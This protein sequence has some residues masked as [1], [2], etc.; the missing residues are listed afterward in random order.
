MASSSG[1]ATSRARSGGTRASVRCGEKA[2]F[3]V[4]KPSGASSRST[5]DCRRASVFDVALDVDPEDARRLRLPKRPSLPRCSS[6]GAMPA[7]ARAIA[8]SMSGRRLGGRLAE[9]LEREVDALRPHPAQAGERRVALER[10]AGAGSAP[11]ARLP[12]ARWRR[13]GGGR[14]TASSP[15]PSRRAALPPS[16]AS[17]SA[18]VVDGACAA[19]RSGAPGRSAGSRCR[20]GG[21]R[22]DGSHRGVGGLARV[23][24]RLRR[25]V[26]VDVRRV[27]VRRCR[28]RRRGARRRCAGRGACAAKAREGFELAAEAAGVVAAA[29]LRD[30]EQ[31]DQAVLRAPAPPGVPRPRRSGPSPGCPAAARRGRARRRRRSARSRARAAASAML[32]CRRGRCGRRSAPPLRA[33]SRCAR[34]IVSWSCQA[35]PSATLM[36]TPRL[37]HARQQVLRRRDLGP[38]I[39]VHL[40]EGGVARG[41]SRRGCRARP[42]GRCACGSR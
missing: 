24:E 36:S 6:N 31:Q 41:R 38:R 18:G 3:S 12:A 42:A 37:V 14:A 1:A 16:T 35:K 13:R 34:T 19:R 4:G 33:G 26:D 5:C 11:R 30:V 17:R 25:R 27:A 29:G 10:R 32:T 9:E 8:A 39:G 28:G 22:R 23:E 7:T 21:V 2:R 40:G 20:T 15:R